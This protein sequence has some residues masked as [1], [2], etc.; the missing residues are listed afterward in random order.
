MQAFFSDKRHTTAWLQI[1]PPETFNVGTTQRHRMIWYMQVK[2][3]DMRARARTQADRYIRTHAI[4]CTHTRVN[5]LY[6]HTQRGKKERKTSETSM[7]ARFRIFSGFCL[8][9]ID[10]LNSV[11]RV[12]A[13]CD[14][15]PC[16]CTYKDTNLFKSS[17]SR[18]FRAIGTNLFA[19]LSFE[20]KVVR[21]RSVP[22]AITVQH[23]VSDFLFHH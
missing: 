23:R 2:P 8:S 20:E 17:L 9:S 5:L 14:A 6:K 7:P 16:A 18:R 15:T 22:R 3:L 21:V 1:G 4:A 11:A 12:H 13:V 19:N 10:G